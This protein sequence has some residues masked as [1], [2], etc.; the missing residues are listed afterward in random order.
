[1]FD[2]IVT[3][4]SVLLDPLW[5]QEEVIASAVN[6]KENDIEDIRSNYR[7]PAAQTNAGHCGRLLRDARCDTVTNI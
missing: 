4:I 3:K 6:S 7:V 2:A 5:D 1:M